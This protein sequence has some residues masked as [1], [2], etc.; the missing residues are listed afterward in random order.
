MN[1]ETVQKSEEYFNSGY[2]CAES[3]LLAISE[4]Q[5][6]SSDLIPRIATGFC[7]GMARTAGMCGA[8]SG[9]IMAINLVSG[10][11]VPN[12]AVDQNYRQVR[13]FIHAFKDAFGSLQCPELI[14]CDLDADEGQIYFTEHNLKEKCILLAREATRLV[15]E[16]IE[17]ESPR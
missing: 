7:S 10:R 4:Q 13:Q 3:V 15:L 5:R 14:G 8:V 17:S 2:Y 16:A 11:N 12:G 1:E 6:I 9:G